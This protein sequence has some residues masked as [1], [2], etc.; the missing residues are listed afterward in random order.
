LW[1]FDAA[2]FTFFALTAVAEEKHGEAFLN[3]NNSLLF[4]DLPSS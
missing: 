1:R 2:D 3:E 4:Q